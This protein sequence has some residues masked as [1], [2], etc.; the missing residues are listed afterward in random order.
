MENKTEDTYAYRQVWAIPERL[1]QFS[2]NG[3]ELLYYFYSG[4][5]MTPEARKSLG[6]PDKMAMMRKPKENNNERQR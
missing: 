5:T 1:G 2:Q 4:D 3:W 6:L